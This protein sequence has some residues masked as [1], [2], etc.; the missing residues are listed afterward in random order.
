MAPTKFASPKRRQNQDWQPKPPEGSLNAF[1]P[2]RT[3]SRKGQKRVTTGP[4]DT[5]QEDA[6]S[7]N[8]TTRQCL[9]RAAVSRRLS[10]PRFACRRPERLKR[11]SMTCLAKSNLKR[12]LPCTDAALGSLFLA[13]MYSLGAAVPGSGTPRGPKVRGCF[14]PQTLS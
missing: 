8:T 9:G 14:W 11:R 3:L 1:L 2:E 5:H 10:R 13:R 12:T 4:K 7:F 6:P